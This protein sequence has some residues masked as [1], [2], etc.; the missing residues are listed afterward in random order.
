MFRPWK[1]QKWIPAR[2]PEC[3]QETSS[4]HATHPTNLL[5]SPAKP[6]IFAKSPRVATINNIQGVCVYIDTL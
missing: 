2:T 1:A 5:Y 3:K 6:P 4:E